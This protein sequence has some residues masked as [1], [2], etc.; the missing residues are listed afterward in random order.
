MLKDQITPS[1]LKELSTS[2]GGPLALA[3]LLGVGKDW[4]YRRISGE[5]PI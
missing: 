2:V 3:Q 5:T 1:D 4:V